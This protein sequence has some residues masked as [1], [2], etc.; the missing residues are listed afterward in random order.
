[1]GEVTIPNWPNPTITIR[2]KNCSCG[3]GNVIATGGG[4]VWIECLD[5]GETGQERASQRKAAEA[6]NTERHDPPPKQ[7]NRAKSR[8]K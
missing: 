1:M 5:C 3:S 2:L 7:K 6:W 8:R 4:C